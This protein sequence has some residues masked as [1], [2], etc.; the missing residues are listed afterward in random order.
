M[1]YRKIFVQIENVVELSPTAQDKLKIIICPRCENPVRGLYFHIHIH[2][3][4]CKNECKSLEPPENYEIKL[5]DIGY[6]DLDTYRRQISF[7]QITAL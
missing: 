2:S 7:G 3:Q 5:I 6:V 1:S 4:R